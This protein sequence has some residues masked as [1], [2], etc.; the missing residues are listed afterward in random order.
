MDISLN[1]LKE[2]ISLSNISPEQIKEKL[3]AH[4]VEV[5]KI[6]KKEDLFKNKRNRKTP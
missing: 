6:T 1:W 3:T 5:E 2:F 4:T